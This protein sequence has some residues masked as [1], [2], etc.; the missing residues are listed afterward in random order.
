M[1]SISSSLYCFSKVVGSIRF[2]RSFFSRRS[3]EGR[4]RCDSRF[5][6]GHQ[7]CSP[8]ATNSTFVEHRVL[9]KRGKIEFRRW[10]IRLIIVIAHAF[11]SVSALPGRSVWLPESTAY[12][13]AVG[14][15]EFS[16]MGMAPIRPYCDAS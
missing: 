7:F 10:R 1:N 13:S 11:F 6:I 16:R 8:L 14:S 9:W 15:I 12:S 2:R 3:P 4:E 5:R